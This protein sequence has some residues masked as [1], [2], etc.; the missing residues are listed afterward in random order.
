M[1]GRGGK[2]FIVTNLNDDGDGSFRKAAIANEPRIIV[3]AISGTIHLT[4][5]ISIKSNATIAGH[6][7]PGD[8]ICIADKSIQLGGD[9]II[10]R[11]IRF[12]LGDKWQRQA[13]MVD[14]VRGE[15]GSLRTRCGGYGVIWKRYGWFAV[16]RYA[17]AATA[18]GRRLH[19]LRTCERNRYESRR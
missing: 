16:V 12:R 6:S 10:L 3:F 17:R 19:G 11:Y 5:S 18:S 7:A 15:H 1:G 14:P 13:G 2:V 8:G 9:N 4:S